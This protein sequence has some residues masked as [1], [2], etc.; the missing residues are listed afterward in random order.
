MDDLAS[1]KAARRAALTAEDGWLNLTDRVEIG[2]GP[3]KVGPQ[4]VGRAADNDLVLSCGPDHLGVL[5]LT[6]AGASFATADGAVQAFQPAPGG[7]PQLR[8]PPL[9]LELH[10]VDG[11]PALRVRDLTAPRAADLR[12]F[13][14]DPAWVIRARWER[15]AAPEATMIGQRGGADTQVTLTHV[16]RFSHGGHDIA[17]VPTHWKGGQPMFVI[18]D[19]T[20]GRQTYGA[21]R[22]LM[23][24]DMTE[25]A[26]TLDFNRAFTPP[27]GFTPHAICPLPPR[28]N[29][30]PFAVEA[31]ELAP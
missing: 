14:D 2:Q 4:K 15:L 3:Q 30:L 31:G 12:Y 11:T 21:S 7:F 28:Q 1:W 23:G 17:L 22:F 19:A 27:C 26:I 10:T 8:V 24:E 25:D 6:E 16:A 20:S 5:T 18:R 9:L 29:I 13:P